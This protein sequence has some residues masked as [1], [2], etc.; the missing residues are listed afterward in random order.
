VLGRVAE[1]Y[2]AQAQEQRALLGPVYRRV[3][4]KAWRRLRR[5]M[6]ERR[7]EAEATLARRTPPRERVPSPAEEAVDS[8]AV[9]A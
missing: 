3:R 1:R 4:G 5:V 6:D 8:S 2:R 7:A 9:P